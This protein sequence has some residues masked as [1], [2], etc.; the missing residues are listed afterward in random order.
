M[1]QAPSSGE[2]SIR[3]VAGANAARAGGLADRRNSR[4]R[5]DRH[6]PLHAPAGRS[7]LLTRFAA[8]RSLSVRSVSASRDCA[9]RAPSR[10]LQW[11]LVLGCDKIDRDGVE[12]ARRDVRNGVSP[13][14]RLPF[15]RTSQTNANLAR[16]CHAATRR[17]LPRRSLT[18]AGSRSPTAAGAPV[19]ACRPKLD[20]DWAERLKAARTRSLDF[21][22]GRRSCCPTRSTIRRNCGRA[23]S[24]AAR[25]GQTRYVRIAHRCGNRR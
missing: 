10:H 14:V 16:R 24:R 23:E 22:L 7:S 13:R 21:R 3:V 1:N 4:S 9:G 2:R 25:K 18:C 5:P 11:P 17:S 20:R 8:L 15:R 6:P 12:M 19:A